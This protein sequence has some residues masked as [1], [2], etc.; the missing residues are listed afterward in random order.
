MKIIYNK[1]LPVKGFSAI[2][3]CGVV[4]ARRDCRPLSQ[5][6]ITHESIHTCQQQEW[7]YVGFF[8]LYFFEWIFKGYRNISFEKE[9]YQYQHLDYYPQ[10]RMPYQNYKKE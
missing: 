10:V 8:V 3:L 5:T 1:F 6:T 2:N 4:F 9:A 7:L